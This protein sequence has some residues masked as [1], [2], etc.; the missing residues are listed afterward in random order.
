MKVI[1][2]IKVKTADPN[3]FVDKDLGALAENV[4]CV[5]PLYNEVTGEMLA[6][7]EKKDLL[8]ELIIHRNQFKNIEIDRNNIMDLLSNLRDNMNSINNNIPKYSIL[9]SNIL[10]EK[11]F[12]KSTLSIESINCQLKLYNQYLPTC[13]INDE[14]ERYS[15]HYSI[16]NENGSKIEVFATLQL[17][18]NEAATSEVENEFTPEEN[19][20]Y[21]KCTPS[22]TNIKYF[23]TDLNTG[24]LTK[25]D[26]TNILPGNKLTIT[27]I[28]AVTIS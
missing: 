16:L 5:F 6:D 21:L 12:F 17:S 1:R 4:K 26:D 10:G 22:L 11:Y 27:Q 18:F 9:Y 14:D 25:L 24:A 7:K 20:V 23:Q 28:K 19:E 15:I 2:K 13:V 8:S 3:T